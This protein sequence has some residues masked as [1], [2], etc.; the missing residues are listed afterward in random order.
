MG[1][2]W[3]QGTSNGGIWG[4]GMGVSGVRGAQEVGAREQGVVGESLG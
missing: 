2:V 1:G 3:G 4:E